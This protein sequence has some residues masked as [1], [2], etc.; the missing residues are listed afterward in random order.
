MP[1]WR[2][3]PGSNR[4]SLALD[5]AQACNVPQPV[6]HRAANLYSH[7]GRMSYMKVAGQQAQ[8]LDQQQQLQQQGQSWST[9][10]SSSSSAGR[11]THAAFSWLPSG[12][13]HRHAAG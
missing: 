11:R 5:V 13:T 9:S 8:Q 6:L 2:M 3:V 10:D 1:T 12:T 4:E 7:M